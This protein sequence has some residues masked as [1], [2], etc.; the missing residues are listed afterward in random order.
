MSAMKFF[1]LRMII[2]H[3]LRGPGESEAARRAP[4]DESA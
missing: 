4:K 2:S 1:S 3:R